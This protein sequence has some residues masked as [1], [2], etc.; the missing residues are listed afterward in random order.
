ML[1]HGGSIALCAGL[2]IML[3]MRGYVRSYRMLALDSTSVATRPAAQGKEVPHEAL[4]RA[5]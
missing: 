3:V 5:A 4:R 1:K 2:A